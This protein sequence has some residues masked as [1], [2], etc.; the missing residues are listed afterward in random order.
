MKKILFFT[1]ALLGTIAVQAQNIVTIS[2]TLI[3]TSRT[4][5]NNNI[6]VIDG[7]TNFGN[8]SAGFLYV[9]N[10]AVLTIEP[11]TIIKSKRTALVIT[12]GS[13]IEAVGTPSQPIVFTSDQ[14]AGNRQP[15]DWGGLLLFGRAPMNVSGGER[16]GEGGISVVRSLG[17]YGGGSTPDANDNS[18]TLRYVR[19]EFAGA[20]A[21]PNS[22][23]NGL[24]MGAV[25]AGTTIDHIMVSHGG[26]DSFEWFGGTVNGKYLISHRGID[27]DFDTDFGFSGK[28][29]FGVAQRDSLRADDPQFSDSNGFESDNDG[30]GSSATPITDATFTNMTIVGPMVRNGQTSPVGRQFGNAARLRRRSSQNLFNS[31]FTAFQRSGLRLESDTTVQGFVLGSNLGFRGNILAG[32]QNGSS[33]CGSTT[34]RTV[35]STACNAATATSRPSLPAV[36]AADNI[37]TAFI[38]SRNNRTLPGIN[39]AML[40]NMHNYTNPNFLPMTGS[41]ALSGADTDSR[42]SDAFFTPTTYVGAFGDKDWTKCWAEWSAETADYTTGPINYFSNAPTSISVVT[43]TND[44][45]LSLP[46]NFDAYA[47]S[48]GSTDFST[49]VSANGTYFATVTNARGCEAVVSVTVSNIVGIE[50]V[51]DVLNTRLVPNPATQGQTTLQLGL[52]RDTEL[53]IELMNMNGQIIAQQQV[54]FNAGVQ[55]LDINTAD[56]SNGL[57]FVNIRTQNE[58]K[59]LKLSVIK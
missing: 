40:T 1:V 48:N 21:I 50:N 5:T 22:E 56:L 34:G 55:S 24:T 6:Y 37:T 3:T 19:I 27:D 52:L 12:R 53:A 9:S 25:G 59:S 29:Q 58:V 20:A 43:G 51:V 54:S 46:S 47:W 33:Q 26:D 57:Y 17:F 8:P 2:D 44:A 7:V 31:V 15:G 32:F 45:T 41:P 16:Q 30:T 4:W 14:A 10:G 13:R 23:T 36:A 35:F 49:V 28:I 11:G 18:G 38:Q 39:D 42:L